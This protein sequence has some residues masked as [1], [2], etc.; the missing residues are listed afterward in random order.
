MDNIDATSDFLKLLKIFKI[1]V[2]PSDEVVEFIRDE[3]IAILF[4]FLF[5][6]KILLLL[7]EHLTLTCYQLR[8]SVFLSTF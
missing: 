3:T 8:V 2:S 5:V 4:Y 6:S 7:R 1:S